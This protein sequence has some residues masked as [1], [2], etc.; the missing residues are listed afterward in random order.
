M[1]TIFTGMIYIFPTEQNNDATL[2]P[3]V[4]LL[5][6]CRAGEEH[7]NSSHFMGGLGEAVDKAEPGFDG[8]FR[9]AILPSVHVTPG[10]PFAAKAEGM[11]IAEGSVSKILRQGGF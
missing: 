8:R 11:I 1:G 9:A 10:M 5:L 7:C 4:S 3:G 6:S 2:E